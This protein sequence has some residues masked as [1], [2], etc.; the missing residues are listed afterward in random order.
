MLT[1]LEVSFD[2]DM[3]KDSFSWTGGGPSFPR[4]SGSPRWTDPRTC[5][6]PVVLEPDR[7]YS[8]GINGGRFTGFRDLQGRPAEPYPLIFRTSGEHPLPTFSH[9]ETLAAV[10]EL[11]AAIESNYSYR[12]RLGLDWNALFREHRPAMESTN[13]ALSFAVAAWDLLRSAQDQHIAVRVDGVDLVVPAPRAE[14]NFNGKQ[15]SRLVP[16]LRKENEAVIT[17]QFDDGIGYLLI[18]TWAKEAANDLVAAQGALTRF[19]APRG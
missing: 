5:V 1:E 11:R 4:T 9:E 12:D 2:R 10:A 17:G 16:N 7:V 6:L 8:L 13:D 3:S 19:A 14:A 18:T 15:L